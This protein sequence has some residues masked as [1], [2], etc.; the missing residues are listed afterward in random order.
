MRARAEA[1]EATRERIA[2]AAMARFI[3]E[4]YEDVTIAV[5]G[6]RRR[7]LAPDGA[8]PLRVEGGPVHGGGRALHRRPA[9]PAAPRRRRRRR[10]GRR[11]LVE[12]Y[13]ESGDG[14]VR[15]A[16]ARRA[17]R[18]GGARSTAA[19]GRPPGVARRGLRRPPAARRRPSAVARWRPCTRPPT[20]HLEAPAARPRP[21]PAGRAAG[22]DRHGR[23]A[24]VASWP[25]DRRGGAMSR[26]Y[27][28]VCWD[29]GGTVP[30]ELS[31]ARGAGR[32][33]PPRQRA[34][35]PD[36]RGG[37]AAAGAGF[38]PVAEGAPPG[39]AP[40]RGR[41]AARFRGP[42]A[43]PADRPP[44]RAP[45]LRAGRRAGGGD[46]PGRRGAGARRASCR[47]SCCSGRRSP[48]R[49]PGCRWRR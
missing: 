15:L 8:Q 27:L 46:R 31:V 22:H 40:A 35:R 12:E 49:P 23:A 14:N 47:A 38:R 1:V 39:L 36:D 20:C 3:A 48:P 21:R 7:R 45:G 42:H 28:F 33:R 4:P 26:H 2:R 41:P 19:R 43:G 29:G 17:L 9:R 6:G 16:A 24:I 11:V 10:R 34:G 30:P 5:G 32:P 13:E 25:P 18:G 44:Q 37:G